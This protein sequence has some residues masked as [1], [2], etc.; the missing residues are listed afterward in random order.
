MNINV[1]ITE[2]NKRIMYRQLKEYNLFNDLN[3]DLESFKEMV[4]I[5]GLLSMINKVDVRTNIESRG[6]STTVNG[7]IVEYR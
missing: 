5:N 6:Y 4:F 2:N 3:M 7:E 1:N